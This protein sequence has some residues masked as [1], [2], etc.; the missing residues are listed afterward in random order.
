[1]ALTV[2]WALAIGMIALSVFVY[3]PIGVSMT[4]GVLLVFGHNLLGG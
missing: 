3:M 4:I 2:I 1:M